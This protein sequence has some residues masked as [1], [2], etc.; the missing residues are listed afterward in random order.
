MK[1]FVT[2]GMIPLLLLALPF[3]S[4]AQLCNQWHTEKKSCPPSTDNFKINGQS[5]SAMMYKGQKSSLNVIFHDRQDYRIQICPEEVLGQQVEF[6]IR[7]GNTQEVLYDNA[8]EDGTLIFEFSCA[9]TQRMVLEIKVPDE[10]EG[11][12]NKLSKLR[13][14]SSG[15]LG[16]LIEYMATPKTGF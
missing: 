6:K 7:D 4:N 12:G 5:R 3:Y 13:S 1:K 9:Q 2:W 16:V 10:G 11:G 15:C 8:D 14:T